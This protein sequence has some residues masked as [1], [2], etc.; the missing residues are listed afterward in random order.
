MRAD[1]LDVVLCA[2]LPK[3]L[4]VAGRSVGDS[5]QT[6]QLPLKSRGLDCDRSKRPERR[7]VKW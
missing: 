2:A 7:V 4:I 3:M 1:D 5:T 6:R